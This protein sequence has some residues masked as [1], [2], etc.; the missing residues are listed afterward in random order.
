[1]RSVD[2]QLEWVLS[3]VAPL[4]ALEVGLLEARGC[5]LAVAV[6][7]PWPVPAFDHAA[8]DG[9]ALIA[10]DVAG[11]SGSRA[12]ALE[13]V[14]DVPAGYRATHDVGPGK[15]V[16]IRSGAP[17][18]A[19]ADAVVATAQTDAGMPS[20][21]VCAPVRAGENIRFAGTEIA[22]GQEV[23][24]SGSFVGAREVALLA[25]VGR[26]R[27][28]VRPKPRVV[29]LSTGTE[30]IEPGGRLSPGLMPDSNGLMLTAACEEAGALA[31]RAGPVA[32]EP[33]ALSNALEDQLVRADLIV[34]AGGVAAETYDTLKTVLDGLGSVEFVRVAMS[35]AMAQGYGHL[36]FEAVPVFT[37]PGDP[38]AAFVS[39]ETFVRPVIRAMLGR[40]ERFRPLEP[41]QLITPLY[42]QVGA[43][44][45][46]LAE[47]TEAAR[48]LAV[49][50]VAGTGISS[51]VAADA[52]IVLPEAAESASAG[53]T[54]SVLRLDRP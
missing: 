20:V 44:S 8:V 4:A 13:V 10:L 3:G 29:V 45:F 11:A 23:L 36:G 37:L 30:L 15:A 21:R 52:L 27:V 53:S 28:S 54:V 5:H 33:T 39:F 42:S 50:A 38:V 46:F 26:S 34:I 6:T 24:G 48:G 14:D 40:P 7:A 9:Y 47:L 19:G 43:R 31:Y 41:A 12:V 51:L 22:A 25:A 2:E 17:I 32:D 35:P 18:P 49:A 16:R 1:M